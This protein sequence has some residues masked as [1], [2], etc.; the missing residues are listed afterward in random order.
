MALRTDPPP[1]L[2]ATWWL[3]YVLLLTMLVT[4]AVVVMTEY[5][6]GP[7]GV[8]TASVVIAPHVLAAVLLVAWN[9][10]AM[11][12]AGRLVPASRYH[13]RSN[14]LLA[15]LLWLTAFAAP[16]GVMM[17]FDR[18]QEQF[19]EPPD[20]MV[21]AAVSGLAAVIGLIAVWLPFGYLAEQARRIGAPSRVV[22]LWFS[23]SL[24]AAGGAFMIVSIG[25]HDVLAESGM[26]A[27]D[28]ALQT[29]VGYG[30]P[31]LVFALATWQATTVFDEVIDLRWQRW[32]LEWEMTLRDLAAQPVPG[33]EL[34]DH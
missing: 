9:A 1:H 4:I 25:L 14:G 3:R 17:V 28:R 16:F 13:R 10:L 21:A 27:A 5:A 33:P 12:D 8:F 18:A 24:F 29:A 23:M 22:V 34:G 7:G 2:A 11:L 6:I 30:V 15:A 31:A 20:D 19:G 26:T 32:R